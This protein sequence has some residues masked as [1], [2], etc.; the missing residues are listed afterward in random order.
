MMESMKK[1]E[2]GTFKSVVNMLQ[3]NKQKHAIVQAV[4]QLSA[5]ADASVSVY[6]PKPEIS[7]AAIPYMRFL[8][9][10]TIQTPKIP[11]SAEWLN[12][13]FEDVMSCKV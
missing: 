9:N 4:E 5:N 13:F 3:A 7:T 8:K 12:I 6:A 11:K 2:N 10:E 1:G